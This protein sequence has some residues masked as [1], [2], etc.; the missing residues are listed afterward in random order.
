MLVIRREL[1]ALPLSWHV[2]ASGCCDNLSLVVVS[3]RGVQ[4]V[5]CM[6]H[7][8]IMVKVGEAKNM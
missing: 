8:C 5:H 7:K 1:L 3:A 6:M 2:L 4:Y